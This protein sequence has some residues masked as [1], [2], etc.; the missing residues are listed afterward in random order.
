MLRFF[1]IHN[2]SQEMGRRCRHNGQRVARVAS[3]RSVD[4]IFDTPLI[5][6]LLMPLLFIFDAFRY[7]SSTLPLMLS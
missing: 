1:A 7:F 3:R 2:L 4:A 5:F 6:S